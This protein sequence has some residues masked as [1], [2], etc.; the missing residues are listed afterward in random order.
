MAERWYWTDV[1][2]TPRVE[3]AIRDYRQEGL[4]ARDIGITLKLERAY[5]D[6]VLAGGEGDGG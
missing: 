6:R 2:D 3:Q 5:V 4:S 1:W